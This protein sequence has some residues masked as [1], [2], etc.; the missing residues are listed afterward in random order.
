MKESSYVWLNS[1]LTSI[2][3]GLRVLA[4]QNRHEDALK[5]YELVLGSSEANES[6]K[7]LAAKG[8][9]ASRASL[10]GMKK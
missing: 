1:R 9:K 5:V 2:H 8:A 3:A 7:R 10:G 4:S 6:D